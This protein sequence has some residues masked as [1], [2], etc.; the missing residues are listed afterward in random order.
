M[1]WESA[2]EFG[3]ILQRLVVH[4]NRRPIH[5]GWGGREGRFRRLEGWTSTFSFA[6]PSAPNRVQLPLLAGDEAEESRKNYHFLGRG[7]PR[8]KGHP[9]GKKREGKRGGGTGRGDA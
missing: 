3:A 6:R 5:T 4:T 2:S 1:A 7:K 8:K 9:P